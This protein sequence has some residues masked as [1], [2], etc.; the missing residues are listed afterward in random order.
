MPNE[1]ILEKLKDCYT[2]QDIQELFKDVRF[3]NANKSL[4]F[5]D[6]VS[7]IGSGLIPTNKRLIN[8]ENILGLFARLLIFLKM[9]G[10]VGKVPKNTGGLGYAGS[11]NSFFNE[12]EQ[13]KKVNS[14]DEVNEYM[15]DAYIQVNLDKGNSPK[16]IYTKF[17][18]VKEHLSYQ[19]IE[20]PMFL[21]L[22]NDIF[23]SSEKFIE[24]EK[25]AKEE[26][27]KVSQGIGTRETY[28][29]P[30]LK[31]LISYSID[32]LENYSNELLDAAEFIVNTKT[33]SASQQYTKSVNFFQTH[34]LFKEQT[35]RELQNKVKQVDALYA[36]NKGKNKGRKL[37]I[38]SIRKSCIEA[39]KTLEVACI[40]ISLMMTGM[41]VS[42]LTTLDRNLNIMQDEHY[43]LQRIVYKTA[44]T[45]NGE[46]LTMPIPEI[47][48][49]ALETL[50]RLATI[51]DDNAYTNII[52][53]SIEKKSI[54]PIRTSRINNL[55]DWYC[56]KLGLD[57]TITPH[58][59]RHAMAYLIVH[60]HENDGLEL[61]RMFLGHTSITMTLQYM[62]HYNNEIKEAMQELTEEESKYLVTKITEQIHEKK[63]LF[64]E[65]GKR[66]TQGYKFAGQQVDNFTKLLRKGLLQLINEQ[67]L[68][69][70]QTPTNL[71]IHDLSK[72]EELACQ[73]GFNITEI[74]ANGPAPSRCKGANCGCSIYFEEHIE[75]L[76]ENMYSDIDPE[77]RTRLE[78]NTYFME[79]GGFEQ[80]PFRKL[81]K[82]YDEYKEGSA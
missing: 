55:L 78:Q 15:I 65:N 10:Y 19:N 34:K 20:L 12:L 47:C 57:K 9:S 49:T 31:K 44:A 24:L 76:K 43:N 72:P 60:I 71:C 41:R 14:I 5:L 70:I 48:K 29:L 4:F 58:Q 82:E 36:N 80:D 26:F 27:N 69:I 7:F 61:A 74:V 21:Q 8:T 59:F 62:A 1:D 53:Q 33:A 3:P 54:S 63:R 25:A 79:A 81:I 50:S 51:K 23:K 32:Y 42:E 18:Y 39:V 56:E 30:E 64:G 45:K 17:K 11:I 22:N 40:S 37:N 13:I 77:L 73:R 52:L 35:L 66:L 68:A 38:S 28:P 6:K 16:T 75:Q 2:I 67:K 46:P